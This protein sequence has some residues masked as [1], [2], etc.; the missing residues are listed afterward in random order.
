MLTALRKKGIST[1]K[2]VYIIPIIIIILLFRTDYYSTYDIVL[3]IIIRITEVHNYNHCNSP[4]DHDTRED[5]PLPST[6]TLLGMTFT[7]V[8]LTI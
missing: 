8:N 4:Q 7:W 3:Y 5:H 1:F 2:L 6:P